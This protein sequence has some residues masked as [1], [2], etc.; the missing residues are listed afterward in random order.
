M[1]MWF[2]ER[3]WS[4]RMTV[5]WA[6]FLFLDHFASEPRFVRRCEVCNRRTSHLGAR[7]RSTNGDVRVQRTLCLRCMICGDHW[8]TRDEMPGDDAFPLY[9]VGAGGDITP[10]QPES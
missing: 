1:W 4:I 8:R 7:L 6:F 9:D 5:R 10:H 2:E 3:V